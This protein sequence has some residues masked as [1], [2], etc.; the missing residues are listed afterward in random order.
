MLSISSHTHIS[1][2]PT[3]Q[4]DQT[5]MTYT[6]NV[7]WPIRI[8]KPHEYPL[9]PPQITSFLSV[10]NT[11]VNTQFLDIYNLFTHLDFY[12]LYLGTILVFRV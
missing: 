12:S 3:K 9:L 1:S 8:T 10:Q 4:H 2:A 5:I 6:N 7:R 11:F